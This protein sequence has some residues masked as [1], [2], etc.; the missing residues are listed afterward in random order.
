MSGGAGGE[1]GA[2][3]AE[4][5][6][7]VDDAASDG[8]ADAEDEPATTADA[9]ESVEGG[10]A[11][12]GAGALAVGVGVSVRPHATRIASIASGNGRK[13][14]TA[15]VFTPDARFVPHSGLLGV[16]PATP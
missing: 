3:E 11:T 9:V 12:P 10:G 7:G 16:E 15:P 13:G 5:S 6:S 2:A 1:T 14:L 4:A 8:G